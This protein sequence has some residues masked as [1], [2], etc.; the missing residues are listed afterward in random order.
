MNAQTEEMA[1]QVHA[2]RL[3][4]VNIQR[5]RLLAAERA[6][7]L[8]RDLKSAAETGLRSEIAR[9]MAA[10]TGLQAVAKRKRTARYAGIGAFGLMLCAATLGLAWGPTQSVG[11]SDHAAPKAPILAAEPGDRLKLAL[12]Y[13]VSAPSAR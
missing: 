4:R 7:K 13:S 8:E 1:R 12:S 2:A 3:A 6:E 9:A 10:R 5:M 11:A